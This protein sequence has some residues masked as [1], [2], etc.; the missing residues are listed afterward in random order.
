MSIE[1]TLPSDIERSSFA[2]IRSELASRGIALPARE[3]L[4]IL[5]C[6]H[7]T[8]D[9][10]YAETLSF[11]KDAVSRAVAALK[12]GILLMTDTNM[13]LAGVSRPAL[14]ALG[15]RAFC[16]MA[17]EEIA[18]EARR[19]GATR[20]VAAMRMAA[21]RCP[22]AVRAIGNAPT[23]LLELAGQIDRGLRPALVI[24]VP[25]GF[26]NVVESKETVFAACER[27]GVPCIMARGRKGGST[28]CAAICN[29]L[30]YEAAGMQDPSAR[31]WN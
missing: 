13:A 11:T 6:I 14:K 8:A 29:A 19:L 12:T 21:E 17:E 24:A 30:L 18:E 10:D 28:V 20:A 26:V 15:C 4:V 2:V 7:A 23:A 25:V 9:L 3:A 1:H 31:G 16:W 5:R 27:A 22:E